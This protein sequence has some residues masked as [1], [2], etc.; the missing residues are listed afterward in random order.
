MGKEVELEALAQ[1]LVLDLPDTALPSRTRIGDEDVDPAEMFGD[2][3]ERPADRRGVCHVAFDP[4][5]RPADSLAG[6]LRALDIEQHHLSPGTA[7]RAGRGKTDRPGT[8]GDDCDLPGER[9]LAPLTELRLLQRPVFDVEELGF[10]DRLEP[11][12]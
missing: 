3:I 6:R 8:A 7:D 5:R 11:A 12:D 10:V 2:V 9:F 4:E 1:R